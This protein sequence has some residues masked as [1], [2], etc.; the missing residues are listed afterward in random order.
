MED[1][2]RS[3]YALVHDLALLLRRAVHVVVALQRDQFRVRVLELRRLDLVACGRRRRHGFLEA[4]Q[5]LAGPRVRQHA[6]RVLVVG[7]VQR[8]LKEQLVVLPVLRR[9]ALL[10]RRSD[11]DRRDDPGLQVDGV[12][13][14]H[15]Q[16]ELPVL[17]H[18]LRVRRD[19]VAAASD[20]VFGAV[21]WRLRCTASRSRRTP[22]P[23]PSCTRREGAG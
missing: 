5:G 22:S 21:R 18:V 10:R 17:K 9:V 2:I 1:L 12:R 8:R 16:V 13:R 11:E 23:S 14:A 7:A 4:L 15:G 19:N 20:T 3:R 6:D